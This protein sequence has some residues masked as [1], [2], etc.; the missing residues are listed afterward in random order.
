M[1]MSAIEGFEFERAFRGAVQ[2]ALNCGFSEIIELKPF[3]EEAL[4]HFIKREDV[5][6]F[7]RA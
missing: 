7:Y 6:S 2:F 1:V 3:Q 5:V 4:F